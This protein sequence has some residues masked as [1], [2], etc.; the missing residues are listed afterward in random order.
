MLSGFHIFL[1]KKPTSI[2]TLKARNILR[3]RGKRE[4]Q[5][6]RQRE[7]ERR[8]DILK[9]GEIGEIGEIIEKIK[10]KREKSWHT[11]PAPLCSYPLGYIFRSVKPMNPHLEPIPLPPFQKVLILCGFYP[12]KQEKFANTIF[13]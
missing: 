12:Y 4:R 10:E 2:F 1:K 9:S 6:Q 8:R 11:V 7:T 13:A 3:E 5:R